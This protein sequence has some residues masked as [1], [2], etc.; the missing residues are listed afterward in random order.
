MTTTTKK[1]KKLRVK[2][3]KK[4]QPPYLISKGHNG[5]EFL[6]DA[7][8]CHYHREDG[9]RCGMF[10]KKGNRYCRHHEGKGSYKELID[11][12]LFEQIKKINLQK[13][14]KP[15]SLKE[16]PQLVAI[17][18][19]KHPE[20]TIMKAAQCGI[21]EWAIILSSVFLKLHRGTTVIYTLPSR[22][23]AS[24]ISKQRI[25]TLIHDNSRTF[26]NINKKGHVQVKYDS[27]FE[28]QIKRGYLFLQG[29]WKE[30]QTISTPGD[31]LMHDEIDFCKGDILKK[32]RSRIGNSDYKWIFKFSTP[33]YPE[34]GIHKEFLKS[35]Q[36]HWW[37]KCEHC[38]HVFMLCCSYPDV[39]H[40]DEET[41]EPYFGCVSCH[42]EI[43]RK[44]GWWKA[45]NPSSDKRGY[46][47]TKLAA[48]R[49]SAKD[50]IEAKEEYKTEKDFWNFELGLPYAGEE[51]QI[52][53]AE[54]ES[55]ED[56]RYHLMVRDKFTCAGVDQGGK[57][58]WVV[59]MKPDGPKL[60]MVYVDHLTGINCWHELA[61]IISQLGVMRCVLDALP[62]S[63]K[64]RE[65]QQLFK[66]KVFLA[67]YNENAK[68]GI[69]WQT[70]KGIVT[71]N[72]NMTLDMA[73]DRVRKQSLILP[74]SDKLIDFKK[75][76]CSLVRTREEDK[77]GEVR[78]VYKK[79]RKDHLAHCFN[80]GN[81]ASLKME[82]NTFQI[83]QMKKANPR[84][85]IAGAYTDDVVNHLAV[86]VLDGLI[87]VESIITYRSEKQNGKFVK[88]MAL[89][90]GLQN[91]Y[92]RLEMKHTVANLLA[93]VQNLGI[94]E[95]RSKLIREKRIQEKID[96]GKNE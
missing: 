14:D 62:D 90:E 67:Y 77:Q 2:K 8:Q 7:N 10:A 28:K 72:R 39:L 31:V 32:F 59:V 13:N 20:K 74:V 82:L 18:H 81:I 17:Y 94:I 35:D 46:H 25:D 88:E 30:S 3:L 86:L 95:E 9:S 80:Y 91:I 24:S 42:K 65:F 11:F 29:T 41:D 71:L 56:G 15:F 57:D 4:V 38:G 43:S 68:E 84:S 64:A 87:T 1:K 55:C 49:V 27:I 76:M 23:L 22:S 73:F 69:Q 93:S 60:R 53:L 63:F 75:H 44:K 50:L 89:S 66:R 45:E 70:N 34:F 16:Y 48:P 37:Y 47:V 6:T 96:G 52:N 26:L 19:D 21:T 5:R 61:T 83:H 36:H 58:L 79:V 54:V 12:D 40:F 51:D 92:G 33:T 78:F 85:L